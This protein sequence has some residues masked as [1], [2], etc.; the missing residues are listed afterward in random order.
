MSASFGKPEFDLPPI[1]E[2]ERL[3]E[4]LWAMERTK[5]AYKDLIARTDELVKSQF[6][7]INQC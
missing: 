7:F 2:Q 3:S 1:S 4:L 6:I 5:A